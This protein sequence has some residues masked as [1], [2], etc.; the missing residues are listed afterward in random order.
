MI[1]LLNW[2]ASLLVQFEDK[3]EYVLHD[4]KFLTKFDLV[5][6][7]PKQ[8]YPFCYKRHK[9]FLVTSKYYMKCKMNCSTHLKCKNFIYLYM[10]VH[11]FFIFAAKNYPTSM[12]SRAT[13]YESKDMLAFVSFVV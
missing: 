8:H 5:E 10:N 4:R 13:N 11:A 9:D 7:L 2:Q 3:L 6:K 12:L 1:V